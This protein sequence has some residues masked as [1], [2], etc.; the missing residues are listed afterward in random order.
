MIRS[1][2]DLEVY[3]ESYNLMLIIHKQLR[4]LP[5]F[6]RND[7]NS[8]MR[9]ASKS[10]PGNIAEGWAKRNHEKEFKHHLDIALGSANEMEHH[11]EVAKDLNY[12]EKQ[13]CLQLL[14]RY[15]KLGG[16]L[17]NLKNNWK[18]F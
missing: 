11:V 17:S 4:N 16:K 7:L 9:R 2:R 5:V 3:K 18:T 6:E 15:C 8:Q 1:F 10:I 13:I 14:D 12:W